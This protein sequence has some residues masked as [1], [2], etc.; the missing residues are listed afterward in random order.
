MPNG[1]S[2]TISDRSTNFA[3]ELFLPGV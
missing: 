1:R 3:E 2:A